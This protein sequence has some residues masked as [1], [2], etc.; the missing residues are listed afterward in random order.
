MKLNKRGEVI[1]QEKKNASSVLIQLNAM[2][3][4][5]FGKVP[6]TKS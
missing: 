1:R 6:K 2:Q 5:V 4:A 3:I